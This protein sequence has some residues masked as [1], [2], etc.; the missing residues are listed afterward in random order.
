MSYDLC[1][2]DF[3]DAIE[4]LKEIAFRS[5]VGKIAHVKF[6]RCNRL[7][8]NRFERF[9]R[10]LWWTLASRLIATPCP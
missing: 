5:I 4:Q 8:I 3:A 9:I 7:Q 10:R 2:A 1:I 6:G